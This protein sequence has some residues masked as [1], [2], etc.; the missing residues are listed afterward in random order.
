MQLFL[1]PVMHINFLASNI[2]SFLSMERAEIILYMNKMPLQR[3][4]FDPCS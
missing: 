3:H 2:T 4:Q 1:Y